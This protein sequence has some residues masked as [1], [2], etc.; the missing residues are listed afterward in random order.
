MHHPHQSEPVKSSNRSF[1]PS[2][3]SFL[4]ASK[5]VCHP[6]PPA[7]SGLSEAKTNAT[8]VMSVFLFIMIRESRD[9]AADSLIVEKYLKT[10]IF[11][12]S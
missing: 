12:D 11:L 10:G 7:C 5:S 8:V 2:A 6:S 4:A 1:L 3:A 9:T